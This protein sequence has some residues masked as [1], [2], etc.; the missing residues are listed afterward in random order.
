MKIQELLPLLKPGFVAS[1]AYGAWAWYRLKPDADTFYGQW[2][3]AR[4]GRGECM[5]LCGF[6][7]APFDRNWKDSLMECGN[8]I[9]CAS[10]KVEQK[11]IKKWNS[12]STK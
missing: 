11:G 5:E 10:K 4:V 3:P 8:H 2:L 7:I 1:D 6:D 12:T 9:A